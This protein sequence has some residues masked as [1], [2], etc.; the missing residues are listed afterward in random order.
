MSIDWPKGVTALFALLRSEECPL[1][2][3]V[4]VD[5]R[6]DLKNF[7]VSNRMYPTVH[8]PIDTS[9]FKEFPESIWLSEH[10]LALPCDHCYDA[11]DIRIIG[12]LIH[13]W[14]NIRGKSRAEGVE[15]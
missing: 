1:G 4:I 8:W 11:K 14:G 6:D 12:D 2:F 13:K 3:S 9:T 15:S 7:L 10:I 5:K